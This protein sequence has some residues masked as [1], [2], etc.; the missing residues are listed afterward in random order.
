MVAGDFPRG[1]GRGR[2]R[3]GGEESGVG[4]GVGLGVPFLS[5]VLSS[6]IILIG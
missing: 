3:G 6:Y 1:A 2:P 5:E 4:G